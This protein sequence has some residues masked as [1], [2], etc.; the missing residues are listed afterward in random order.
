MTKTGSKTGK[1]S[2]GV[3]CFQSFLVLA[4]QM[5]LIVFSLV[6]SW[7]LRFEFRI[8]NPGVLWAVAP[9]LILVRLSVMPFFNL[10]HGWWR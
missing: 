7:L 5:G 9:L 1:T 10:M 8:P 2:P 4:L 3:R 6:C